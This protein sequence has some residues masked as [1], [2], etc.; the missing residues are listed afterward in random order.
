MTINAA[1]QDVPRS[2][3]L[4]SGA[5]FKRAQLHE[6]FGGNRY[7]GIV[8]SAREPVVL[9]FHTEEP[10]RQFYRDG[11]DEQGIYWYSGEG[12]EGDMTWNATNRAV[13]DHI[14]RGADLLFFERVQRQGGLWRFSRAMCCIGHKIEHRPDSGGTERNAIVFGL[15]PLESLASPDRLAGAAAIVS[16]AA[17]PK[18]E[19]PIQCD[20]AA[21]TQRLRNVFLRSAMVKEHALQRAAGMC[22]ACNAPAPFARPSGEPYLEVHHIDRLADG[23]PDRQDRVAAICANCHCRCHYGIDA[24]AYNESLRLYI[25]SKEMPITEGAQHILRAMSPKEERQQRST[26]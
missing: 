23:G 4:P 6:R 18:A 15:L 2:G 8:P 10:A 13:R 17:A 1:L 16:D 21:V 25:A 9:L 3:P 14:E 12:T 5:I 20:D 26:T 7:S 11:F 22:E 19:L 24:S